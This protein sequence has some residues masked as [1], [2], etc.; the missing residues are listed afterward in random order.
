[1]RYNHFSMLPEQAFKPRGQFG[2]TLEG[3]VFGGG[4]GG[5]GGEASP[6]SPVAPTPAGPPA[7]QPN[8]YT[9]AGG[10]FLGQFQPGALPIAQNKFNP[11]RYL[12]QNPDV[13]RD[14]NYGRNP[15]QHYQDY[16][17]YEQRSPYEGFQYGPST[18]PM[19]NPAYQ[20]VE[21]DS[22]VNRAYRNI[23]RRAPDTAG[24]SY[25]QNQMRQGMTGQ[26]LV[27][28]FTGS[29]E[30]Q[31][32]QEF[33]RAYTEAFRP[34][35]QEFGPSGQYYQPIYQQRYTNYAQSPGF[36]SPGYSGPSFMNPFSYG[37]GDMRMFEEGGEVEDEGIAALRIK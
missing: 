36:Y 34:G 27:S 26:G 8:R 11:S 24:Q 35:Y 5:G 7:P 20:G 19:Y 17:F 1:M 18:Q 32:Q 37:G 2:M 3:G 31:R 28:G 14:P 15:F 22:L 13:A 25:W 16:G 21:A 12:E 10:G 6:T 30:F 33:D 9:P 4:G 23:L 29:P